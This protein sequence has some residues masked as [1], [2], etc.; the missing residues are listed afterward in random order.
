MGDIIIEIAPNFPFAHMLVS[1]VIEGA[2]QQ[3]F[4]T[5]HLPALTDTMK[6]EDAISEFYKH[7]TF[8]LIEDNKYV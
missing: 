2:H 7:M 8:N 1:T 4:F 6:E 5:K 3:R